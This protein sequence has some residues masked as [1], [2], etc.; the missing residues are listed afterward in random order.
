MAHLFVRPTAV[1]DYMLLKC[2]VDA[3]GEYEV[4]V[5]LTRAADYGVVQC[6][7]D[8]RKTGEPI[9][10]YHSGSPQPP[11]AYSLGVHYLARVGFS[12]GVRVV[13]SNV[14]ATEPATYWGLDCIMLKPAE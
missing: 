12:L 10:L 7:I 6:T 9:D 5:Y 14:D 3:P 4:I 13:D 1:G 2:P 8:G 11:K